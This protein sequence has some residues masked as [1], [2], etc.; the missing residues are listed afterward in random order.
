MRVLRFTLTAALLAAAA[1]CEL[2]EVTT[3]PAED[4]LVVEAVL[5]TDREDQY[6]LLHRSLQGIVAGEA[7]GAR[8]EVTEQ[9]NVRHFFGEA[10]ESCYRIDR[11]YLESDSVDFRGTCYREDFTGARAVRPGRTYDL[12][13][14]T[15]DRRVVRGRTTVPGP[16]ELFPREEAVRNAPAPGFICRLPPGTGMRVD[17]SRADGAWSYVAQLRINGLRQAL[18]PLGIDAPEP[19]EL[20]GLA[21]SESDTTIRLPGEFGVFERFQYDQ[22]LLLAIRDGFPE[23]VR[24]DLVVAAADRNWV[25]GVRGA[26]FNPSGLVRISSV[27]GDGV[28]VF[29][30]L[31]PRRMQIL[32]AAADIPGIPLCPGRV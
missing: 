6:V 24:M 5:R 12:R 2:T 10:G 1:A 20:R 17:W 16:F 21:V 23:G 22:D 18:A 30:S 31:V 28:G 15:L 26:N 29:G 8:V 27:V 3:E 19:L 11:R 4:V 32:V 13:V 14:E 25:N 9:N 7:R